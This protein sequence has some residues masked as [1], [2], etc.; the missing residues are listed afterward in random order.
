MIGQHRAGNTRRLFGIEGWWTGHTPSS[1]SLFS[2]H[3]QP[4]MAPSFLGLFSKRE[5]AKT[6][7]KH[8]D[9][10]SPS[11]SKSPGRLLPTSSAKSIPSPSIADAS[12]NLESPEL[13]LEAE[14]VLADAET[15]P[16]NSTSVYSHSFTPNGPNTSTT[17][18]KMPFR[19]K[20]PSHTK[21][22]TIISRTSIS[23]LPE[24]PPKFSVESTLSSSPSLLPPPSRSAIFASYNDPHIALS[25]RSLPEDVPAVY[26]YQRNVSQN[27]ETMSDP[28]SHSHITSV[29]SPK[30]K[31]STKGGL[32]SWARPRARTKSKASV[33]DHSLHS[34]PVLTLP[35]A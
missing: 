12:E 23:T 17:K 25:T 31:Q 21:L 10:S 8:S 27:Y 14:Y 6:F 4:T 2:Y 32:F 33:P 18:L 13:S 26:S 5:N 19:R 3:L 22:T 28:D 15:S 24:A 29:A 11:R 20:Q 7:Q 16:V 35:P 34:A 30:S 1:P 9:T